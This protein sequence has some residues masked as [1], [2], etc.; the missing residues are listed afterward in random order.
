MLYN[1]QKNDE[2]YK[3]GGRLYGQPDTSDRMQSLTTQNNN[4]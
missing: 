3:P 4:S 2:D 1:E